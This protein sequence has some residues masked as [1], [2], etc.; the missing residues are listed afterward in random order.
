VTFKPVWVKAYAGSYL[1]YHSERRLLM[2]ATPPFPRVLGIGTHGYMETPSTFPVVSRPFYYRGVAKLNKSASISEIDGVI[3]EVD[4]IIA[5]HPNHKGIVHTVSY[6]LR[7]VMMTGSKHGSRLISHS[8]ADRE[9]VLE[10]FKTSAAPLVLVSPSMAEGVSF[11][12]DLARWQVLMKVPFPNLGDPQVKARANE[13][14]DWYNFAT[15]TNVVQTYGRVMR[16]ES[17]WGDTYCLDKNFWW[18]FTTQKAMFPQW[19]AES[20]IYQSRW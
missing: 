14:R 10:Q 11:D 3:A 2:S 9:E 17:D 15:C 16:S 18:M 20:V 12:E 1:L 4:R 8:S 13:D 6:H 7:D 5:A 19:F